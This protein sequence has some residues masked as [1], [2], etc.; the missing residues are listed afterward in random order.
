[1]K[2]YLFRCFLFLISLSA[3][4]YA[5]DRDIMMSIYPEEGFC[6]GT[7][8]STPYGPT[9]IEALKIDD[10]VFDSSLRQKKIIVVARRLVSRYV[11]I[12]I[13]HDAV[14]AG[15][16]NKILLSHDQWAPANTCVPYCYVQSINVHGY[17]ARCMLVEEPAWLYQISVEGNIFCIAPYN[18]VVHNADI[19]GISSGMLFLEYVAYTNP[20]VALIGAT[21]GLSHIAYNAYRAYQERKKNAEVSVDDTSEI[22]TVFLAERFYYEQRKSELITINNELHEFY[23]GMTII[24]DLF[25]S[26]V[27]TFS[28]QFLSAV[29]TPYKNTSIV[30]ISMSAEL[31]LS[32]AQRIALRKAR[33][34]DLLSRETT[35]QHLHAA[36][37][38]HFNALIQQVNDAFAAFKRVLPDVENAHIAW[39]R[40]DVEGS[41]TDQ[42]ASML[43]EKSLMQECLVLQIKRA[44]TE[45][46]LVVMYY[47]KHISCDSLKLTT[48]FMDQ[49]NFFYD[50]S[51]EDE[52]WIQD[53]LESITYNVSLAE[54]YFARRGIPTGVFKNQIK[55]AFNKEQKQKDAKAISNA[56]A[57]LTGMT[58][59]GGDGPRK[60]DEKEDV[61][62]TLKGSKKL[63][64]EIAEDAKKRCWE[65][66]DMPSKDDTQQLNHIFPKDKSG[67]DPYSDAHYAELQELV[68]DPSNFLGKDKHGNQWFNKIKENGEQKWAKAFGKQVKSG[69]TNSS[70]VPYDPELGL[71]KPGSPT[72]REFV[73]R[74]LKNNIV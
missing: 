14:S 64:D 32:D 65:N 60:D 52:Q 19:A 9:P 29:N 37:V 44:V 34:Q 10:V 27:S 4:L 61:L 73:K 55:S 48:S 38:V 47:Q 7:L 3:V 39:N 1:M 57:Q 35:I 13:N 28:S 6:A 22:E 25:S 18:M 53:H 42:V 71:L 72:Y 46:K 23:R 45:L 15:Y 5:A 20:V 24:K 31:K 33:E 16:S 8:V 69:G 21:V 49:L 36:L 63:V 12:T 51:L 67:H 54:H 41:I 62:S 2:R 68:R 43:Y 58:R 70:P 17:Y 56:Q 40:H 59:G 66:P 50:A 74:N 26:Q 11:H 30:D